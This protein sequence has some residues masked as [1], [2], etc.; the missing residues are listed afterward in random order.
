MENMLSRAQETGRRGFI[1]APLIGTVIFLSAVI[2]IVNLQNVEAQASLRVAN[3]AYHNRVSS[4]LEQYRSDLSSI[5]REGLSRTISFYVLSPGWDVFK[6]T[7]NPSSTFYKDAPTYL[8]GTSNDKPIDGDLGGG[9]DG[10]VSLQELKYGKCETANA[11]ARDV[12]CSIPD[13]NSLQ[14]KYGLPQWMSSFLQNFTFEG[15][16]FS[17]SN[18]KQIEYFLPNA[19]IA[20]GVSQDQ[21]LKEYG[22]Y[23]RALLQGSAF[24]CKA[25]ATQSN[26]D[27]SSV[28]QCMDPDTNTLIPGCE[29]GNFFVKVNV[30]NPVT[31]PNT[32]DR[33]E[34]YGTLPR[35]QATDS[36][37]NVFR[38]SGIGEKNFYLPINLRVFQYY[39][40]TFKMYDRLA[41]GQSQ[42]DKNEPSGTE[43]VADGHCGGPSA[44][45]C[46][47]TTTDKFQ[48][49]TGY[50]YQSFFS[51]GYA[52]GDDQK[53]RDA[54]ASA[55]YA[56]VFTSACR[57]LNSPASHDYDMKICSAADCGASELC[58][59]VALGSITL[60]QIRATLNKQEFLNPQSEYCANGNTELCAFYGGLTGAGDGSHDSL[61]LSFQLV[62]KNDAYRI[63]PTQPVVFKWGVNIQHDL[64][65][66]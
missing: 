6:W 39:D 38:S 13:T 19:R 24:D 25:F 11:I 48:G 49:D 17:T 53:A 36:G 22:E 9:A 63:D 14:Y 43:G 33:V 56:N 41:Y 47:H 58:A 37:G 27:G 7:N 12:I 51:G 62:D 8:Q 50:A 35:V 3:D 40:D 54:V 5:F 57:Q 44:S 28:K 4:I 16:T 15:I 30:L 65:T 23:C 42:N 32:N 31:D 1:S 29:S 66:P 34:I 45:D 46:A 26:V 61:D 60:P 55:Y 18:P 64:A 52:P 10:K 2:F 59:N 21:A 20:D